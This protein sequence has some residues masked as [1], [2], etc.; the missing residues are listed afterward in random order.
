MGQTGPG[1]GC[2]LTGRRPLPSPEAAPGA[3]LG[4]IIWSRKTPTKASGSRVDLPNSPD[5]TVLHSELEVWGRAAHPTPFLLQSR[6]Q[7]HRRKEVTFSLTAGTE[8][9]CGLLVTEPGSGL[10]W[11][12]RC[13]PLCLPHFAFETGSH[14]DKAII[15]Q[16]PAVEVSHIAT[17]W[18]PSHHSWLIV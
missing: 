9:V 5:P 13:V 7:R 6:C 14:V 2:S 18:L 10:C 11:D 1:A 8:S 4:E 3:D 16:D 17:A 15:S 12:L